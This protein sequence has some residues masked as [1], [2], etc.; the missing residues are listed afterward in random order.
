[1]IGIIFI[2]PVIV[3]ALPDHWRRDIIRFFP[4][5]AGRVIS[6]TGPSPGGS[7]YLWSAWPQMIV[8]ACYAVGLLAI[9]A[10][11]FRKRDA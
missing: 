6:V 7:A 8:T 2:I 1:V 11:L 4:G 5:E 9:G 10:Y 3:Q